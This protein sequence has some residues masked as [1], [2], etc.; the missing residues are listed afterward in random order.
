MV[1][2]DVPLDW[3]ALAA[4]TKVILALAMALGRLETLA[5]IALFNPDFW[6]R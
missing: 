4:P 1:A 2:G 6:R 3:A 5:I